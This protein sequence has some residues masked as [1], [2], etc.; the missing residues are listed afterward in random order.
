MGTEK[1]T[2][3]PKGQ[4]YIKP[5]K[6]QIQSI[7]KIE[8]TRATLLCNYKI[9]FVSRGPLIRDLNIQKVVLNGNISIIILYQLANPKCKFITPFLPLTKILTIRYTLLLL[10]IFI[11]S[12]FYEQVFWRL[13]SA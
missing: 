12:Y 9:Q 10:Y 8:K 2:R 13:K 6:L 1:S 7:S 4:Q 5:G 3:I 11:H